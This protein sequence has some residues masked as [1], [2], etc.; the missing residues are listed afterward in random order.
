MYGGFTELAQ[1]WLTKTRHTDLMD[2]LTDI[3]GVI[4]GFLFYLM[5]KRKNL[6]RKE[7]VK[8]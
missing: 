5:V 2:F 6:N 4:F 8:Y 3:V 1:G 7:L